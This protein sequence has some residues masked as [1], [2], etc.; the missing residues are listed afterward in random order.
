MCLL[1]L[2]LVV[3]PQDSAIRT[4]Y[5]ATKCRAKTKI[6]AF[7]NSSVSSYRC[8]S[9]LLL[10]FL[11]VLLISCVRPQIG[12]LYPS[13]CNVP[14]PWS[15]GARIGD[16]LHPGPLYAVGTLNVA[17]LSNHNEV[18]ALPYHCPLT[19]VITETCLA[20]DSEPFVREKASSVQ[21]CFV[22][23]CLCKPR[24]FVSRKGSV[25]RGQTGGVAVSSDPPS[26]RS[27]LR[28]A[29]ET[30]LSTRIVERILSLGPN[31]VARI[32]G[33]YGFSGNYESSRLMDDLLNSTMEHVLCSSLPCFIVGDFN[34]PLEDLSFWTQL[35]SRG[36]KDANKMAKDLT[37][38]PLYPTWKGQ[39]RID[40]VLVPQLQGY[41]QS[42]FHTDETVSDHSFVAADF[43]I[44]SPV[45]AV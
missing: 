35:E 5:Y 25:L 8:G 22:P 19:L 42:F 38:C 32:I 39:T 14:L 36:W 34:C 6:L 23:S 40:F 27:S 11:W 9:M 1:S 15:V 28:M 45:S 29:R 2:G 18:V 26:R 30:W 13:Q 43:D 31:L 7:V 20:Q 12:N 10:L 44:P 41:F 37:G 16:A 24:T 4:S 17:S 21:R 3:L 33:I